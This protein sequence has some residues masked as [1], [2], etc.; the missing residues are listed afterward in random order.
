MSEKGIMRIAS[1]HSF[2]ETFARLELAVKSKGM[3]VFAT[4]D[5]GGDAK[6]AGLKMKPT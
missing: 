5:F 3:F 2:D 4:I 1:T 6:R